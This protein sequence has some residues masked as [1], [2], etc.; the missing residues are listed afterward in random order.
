MQNRTLQWL[1]CNRGIWVVMTL[2]NTRFATRRIEHD[3]CYGVIVHMFCEVVT[4]R[5]V[6]SMQNRTL[7]W[8]RCNRS[9]GL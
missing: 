3:K 9:Y 1:R 4:K 5:E 2:H 7:Q 8:L 6:C